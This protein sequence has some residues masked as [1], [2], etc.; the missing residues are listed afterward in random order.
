MKYPNGL[1]LLSLP[2]TAR[3]RA[4][5]RRRDLR[6]LGSLTASAALERTGVGPDG[7]IACCGSKNRFAA[8]LGALAK[9]SPRPFVIV[10]TEQDM[11]SGCIPRS[12]G[13]IAKQPAPHTSQP[14]DWGLNKYYYNNPSAVIISE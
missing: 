10:G 9:R 3:H 11:E 7:P 8:L 6:D 4:E 1:S 5:E 2:V 13:K 14:E 12:P